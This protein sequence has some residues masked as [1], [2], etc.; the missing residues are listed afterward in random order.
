MVEVISLAIRVSKRFDATPKSNRNHFFLHHLN[1]HIA[2]LRAY[3][4]LRLDLHLHFGVF[5]IEL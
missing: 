4:R 1:S 2:K 5:T 3:I